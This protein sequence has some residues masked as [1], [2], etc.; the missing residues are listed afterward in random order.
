MSRSTR[1]L[2]A[3]GA[4]AGP[5]YIAVGLAQMLLREGF[6]P[7]KHALSLLSNG[8]WGWVQIANFVV[9]G[10]LVLAGAIGIRHALRGHA[11]GT[12]APPLLAVYGLGL[13]GAGL[14]VADPSDGFPPGSPPFHGLS[15]SG[16]LHFVFGG[17]GFFA[18]I[19]ACFVFAR[20]FGLAQRQ[21]FAWW[22]AMTGAFFSASFAAVASGA[23]SPLV[24]LTF[25][26][27]VVWLWIWHAAVHARVRA[28]AGATCS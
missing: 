8:P 12:W 9:S 22:S 16:M 24:M 10:G 2:L 3:L 28:E 14:F 15:R 26:A 11:A 1:Q 27:S 19:A 25:Y 7:R 21:G 17:I 5:A 18:V 20:R 6:D 23:K 13:I 4:A